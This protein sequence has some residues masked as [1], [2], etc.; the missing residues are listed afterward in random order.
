MNSSDPTRPYYYI[1]SIDEGRA[2]FF[3]S[4]SLAIKFLFG[5][6]SHKL[7]HHPI[8]RQSGEGGGRLDGILGPYYFSSLRGKEIQ[9]IA[10]FG[11]PVSEERVE[12]V[13]INR[14]T[15]TAAH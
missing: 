9:N 7:P 8:Y 11:H 14:L 5:A 10:L 2:P 4:L 6:E 1:N 13:C 15:L 3:E 12:V